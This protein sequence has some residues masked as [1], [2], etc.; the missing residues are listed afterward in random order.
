MAVTDEPAG[1][2]PAHADPSPAK[3]YGLS[4]IHI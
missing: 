1:P 3:E 2:D 4:L